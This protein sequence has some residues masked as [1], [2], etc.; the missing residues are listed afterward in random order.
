M[1]PDFSPTASLETLKLRATLLAVVREFFVERGYWEVETP[2]LSSE[3]VIDAQ[4]DPFIVEGRF[5]LQTSPEADMKCLLAGGAEAIF[6]VTRAFRRDERGQYHHPEFTM[7][8]WYRVGDSHRDQ[9]A[10]VEELVAAVFAATNNTPGQRPFPRRTY[11]NVFRDTLGIGGLEAECEQLESLA[12]SRGVAVPDSL[13][14]DDRD[15]WL[16]L[17]LAELVEPDLGRNGPEFVYDYPASQAALAK[18]RPDNPPAAERFELYIRGLE[19][20]NGYHELTDADELR[21]RIV[22]ESAKRKSAGL[23]TLP[24]PTRLLAAMDAGLPASAGVALGFDRLLMAVTGAE[25]ID[26]VTAFPPG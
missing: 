2:L 4:L 15:G 21:R 5:F 16:N 1:N 26:D 20:C 6:Q 18:I 22:V 10:V 11:N 12:A 9:M 19:I 25:S 17:L 3:T 13:N 14:S 8:E 24:A 23:S 7:V